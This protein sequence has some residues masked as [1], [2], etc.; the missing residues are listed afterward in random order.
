M[1]L[2]PVILTPLFLVPLFVLTP[3]FVIPVIPMAQ[4]YGGMKLKEIAEQLGLKRTGSIP[5]TIKKLM[6]V[7]DEDRKLLRTFNRI[8]SQYDT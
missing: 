8:K 2:D 7:L 3:L 1:I 5:T 6:V 4:R